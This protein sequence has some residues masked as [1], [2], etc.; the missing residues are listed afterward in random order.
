M[1]TKND[2][3]DEN[4]RLRNRVEMLE[5][6]LKRGAEILSRIETKNNLVAEKYNFAIDQLIYI[7]AKIEQ[8]PQLV[9]GE[10]LPSL[11]VN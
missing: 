1:P 5:D 9:N 4:E 3:M 6:R 8:N 10:K 11:M 2:L 7:K